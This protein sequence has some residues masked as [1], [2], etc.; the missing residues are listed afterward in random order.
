M[1][2]NRKAPKIPEAAPS[3]LWKTL[4]FYKRSC[5]KEG[6]LPSKHPQRAPTH[7]D[8]SRPRYSP[9]ILR[10]ILGVL[11]SLQRLAVSR[12]LSKALTILRAILSRKEPRAALGLSSP[13]LKYSW[14]ILG[15][16]S[17]HSGLQSSLR[18]FPETIHSCPSI[19]L[20]TLVTLS[21]RIQK[22]PSPITRT[23]TE[24]T[25]PH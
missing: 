21:Q 2:S 6:I 18:C 22:V 12:A 13:S 10:E 25:Q 9:G 14:L 11:A 3:W 20:L 8:L 24:D 23:E 1:G 4:P 17:G 7:K 5:G 19:S 15:I 16:F